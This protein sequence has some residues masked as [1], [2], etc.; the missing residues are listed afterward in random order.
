M[1]Q[2]DLGSSTGLCKLECTNSIC[3]ERAVT[4]NCR[5]GAKLYPL[6]P[7]LQVEVQAKVEVEDEDRHFRRHRR[8][9]RAVSH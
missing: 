4:L 8:A 5:V 3:T 9:P 1:D 2:L 6:S 7:A